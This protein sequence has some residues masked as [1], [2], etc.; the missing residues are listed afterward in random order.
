MD[1]LNKV[2]NDKE[3]PNAAKVLFFYLCRALNFSIGVFRNVTASE[4]ATKLNITESQFHSRLRPLIKSDYVTL[5]KTPKRGVFDLYVGKE[6]NESESQNENENKQE[7]ESQC[8][9]D[10]DS[11]DSDECDFQDENENEIEVEVTVNWEDEGKKQNQSETQNETKTTRIDSAVFIA[12][13][14]SPPQSDNQLHA[15][16][17]KNKPFYTSNPFESWLN[18]KAGTPEKPDIDARRATPPPRPKPI[19]KPIPKPAPLPSTQPLFSPPKPVLKPVE[20]PKTQP[21]NKNPLHISNIQIENLNLNSIKQIEKNNFQSIDSKK[22]VESKPRFNH[23]P[24]KRCKSLF[25]KVRQ[26]APAETQ[27]YLAFMCEE[28]IADKPEKR[29]AVWHAV[30]TA[31]KGNNPGAYLNWILEYGNDGIGK[32]EINEY[33]KRAKMRFHAS[34]Q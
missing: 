10:D 33:R 13:K 17:P 21:K 24:T 15:E 12:G 6:D 31:S 8:C 23:L 5:T 30:Y 28:I 2:F 26:I 29:D 7:N 27:A 4:M 16:S 1:R 11:C 14:T 9:R 18:P 22:T 20:K 34:K 3:I 19:P 32:N 25:A